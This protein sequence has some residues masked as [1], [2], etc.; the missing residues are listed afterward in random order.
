MEEII[1]VPSPRPFEKSEEQTEIGEIMQIIS[2]ESLQQRCVE[3]LVDMTA[4]RVMK[5]LVEEVR[6]IP[7][8]RHLER[9]GE[10]IVDLLEQQVVQEIFEGIDEDKSAW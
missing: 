7:Q 9:K 5:D 4:T 1:A 6:L 2:L 8:E 3:Q 10:H